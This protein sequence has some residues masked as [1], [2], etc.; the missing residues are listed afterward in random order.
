M[1]CYIDLNLKCN[2]ADALIS[3]FS[4]CFSSDSTALHTRHRLKD[5]CLLGPILYPSAWL[6]WYQTCQTSALHHH[7]T[8]ANQ[9]S[10]SVFC[11]IS[12][13]DKFSPTSNLVLSAVLQDFSS[14]HLLFSI[15][16]HNYLANQSLCHLVPCCSVT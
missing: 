5:H 6:M 3:L 12:H 14:V 9:R 2:G 11:N 16:S 8:P 4:L 1:Q 15:H 10:F 7:L 13:L